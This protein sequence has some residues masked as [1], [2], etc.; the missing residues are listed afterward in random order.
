MGSEERS[1]WATAREGIP[2]YQMGVLM[3]GCG[4]WLGE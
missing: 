3:V 2:G 1:D 4:S